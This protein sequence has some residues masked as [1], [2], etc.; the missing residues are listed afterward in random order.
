MFVKDSEQHSR[1]TELFIVTKE[2][3][4]CFKV[5]KNNAVHEIN[6]KNI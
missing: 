6:S 1:K 2:K 5:R 3:L 4:N